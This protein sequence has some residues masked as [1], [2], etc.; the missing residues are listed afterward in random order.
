MGKGIQ[1]GITR[2][3]A[4]RRQLVEEAARAGRSRALFSVESVTEALERSLG[5]GLWSPFVLRPGIGALFCRV[6]SGHPGGFSVSVSKNEE[7]GR[8]GRGGWER[9]EAETERQKV[10]WAKARSWTIL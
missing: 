1:E 4:G 10:Q 9:V 8:S 7:D 2:E 3:K 5:T 6:D